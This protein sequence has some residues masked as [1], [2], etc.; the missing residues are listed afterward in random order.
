[1]ELLRRIEP[2]VLFRESLSSQSEH[3][4]FVLDMET[5]ESVVVKVIVVVLL[6]VNQ[7]VNGICMVLLVGAQRIAAV[8]ETSTQYMPMFT[9]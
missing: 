5:L 7:A 2:I 8:E 6:F 4:T 9:I 3:I 1:M